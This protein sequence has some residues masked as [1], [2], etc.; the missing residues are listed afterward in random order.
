MRRTARGWLLHWLDRL[1]TEA[2]RRAPPE[3][4]RRYRL[5]A[6]AGAVCGA[7]TLLGLVAL[8]LLLP[9]PPAL[10]SVGVGVILGYLG[11]LGLL[12]RARSPR[13]PAL[14][15]CSVAAAGLVLIPLA[16]GTHQAATHAFVMMMPLL[17]VYLLG[18]RPGL[19]FTGLLMVHILLL[20]PL[21]LAR[22]APE[23]ASLADPEAW[24]MRAFAVI[25]LVGAWG[26]SWLHG[27]G[28]DEAH[29]ALERALRTLRESEGKLLSLIESTDDL[30]CALDTRGRLVSANHAALE[31][32]R[33]VLG[34]EPRPGEPVEL[35]FSP[36]QQARWR[37]RLARAAGGQRVREE[38][39]VPLGA[40][41]VTLELTVNAVLDGPGRVVGLTLFGRDITE[42]R[43][44][45]AR[46]SELHRSM[47]DVSRQAGMAEIAT[48]ILHNVGNTL[49]S[50]NVSAEVVSE[51]L[52]ELRVAKLVRATELLRE[53]AAQLSTF[54]TESA[55]GKRLPTYLV[56]LAQQ[57]EQ[58]RQGLLAE[59]RTLRENVEHIK[60]VVNMQQ[61]HA[62]SV[63]VE[64]EVEVAQLVRDA[65][66]LH[67]VSFEK[68]GIQVRCEVAEVA[69]LL[70][71][72]HKLL[73]ILLN[74]LGNAR[75]ALLDSGKE[76]KQLTLRV[77]PGAS[78][79]LRI[80]VG[81]NGVG[82]APE[83]LPR[84]FSQGFT[85]K[86]TGHGFGLHI[87]ALTA[88][89]LKGS[90]TCRS[91]GKGLGATFVLEL[92]QAGRAHIGAP[93]GSRP[94]GSPLPLG[95]G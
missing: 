88:R 25:S 35:A 57:L 43:E 65:L 29:T 73:Q 51:R 94:C 19:A 64:E 41:R 12:R 95:E 56:T 39:S 17:A 87:S 58:E 16:M 6:G 71:D 84:M 70:A 53:N 38:L 69:P 7:L 72:R 77:G 62:R 91:E 81:D 13:A 80:E 1:L 11:V 90:L 8:E 75:H 32:F 46:L 66:R 22:L 93:L 82:I 50:V 20:H 60:A 27:V 4:L 79:A 52:R 23:Q 40:R 55:Q 2:Q 36:E 10:R 68:L 26:M 14:L 59:V 85:T 76:D 24:V 42:R 48:G 45:E 5:L 63:G 86:K 30:V 31:L 3:E 61:E 67:A 28:R 83:H 15:L 18:P 54:L 49:N 92:P 21:L 33:Q 9:P 78:G 74:L 89:E 34:R 37:E 44:A 47:L